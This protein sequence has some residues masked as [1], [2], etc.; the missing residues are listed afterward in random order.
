MFEIGFTELLVIFALALVV[1]GPERLPRLAARVGRWM[2]K[3]RSMARQFRDQLE[4]EASSIEAQAKPP[5]PTP[6]EKSPDE[7]GV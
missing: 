1:L 3:A 6:A 7:R 2:G 5:P 4:A